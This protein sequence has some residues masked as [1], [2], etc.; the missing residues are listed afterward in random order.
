[1]AIVSI[2]I[3]TYKRSVRLGEAIDSVLNQ[4]HKNVEVIVVDDNNSDTEDRKATQTFMLKYEDVENVIYIKHEKNKN[5]SAARNTGLHASNGEYICFLDDDDSFYPKKIET[6]LNFLLNNKQYDGCYCQS[7]KNGVAFKNKPVNNWSESILLERFSPQTPTLMFTKQSLLDIGGFDESYQ[8]HQD[9]ELLLRYTQKFALGA[10][11]DILVGIGEN[12]GENIPN[13]NK[14]KAIKEK[15]LRDFAYLIDKFDKKTKK[16]VIA[17]HYVKLSWSFLKSKNICGFVK[18]FAY[19]SKHSFY[20]A[21]KIL[22][23]RIILYIKK[24]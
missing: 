5:G 21:S 16:H 8:R 23:D 17:H 6:Q 22:V 15:Y 18:H 12:D 10:I 20:F 3:P 4:T 14:M 19:A 11:N 9:Y 24:I 7:E 2:I 13:P 1:M